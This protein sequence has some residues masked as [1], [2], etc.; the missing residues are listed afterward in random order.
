MCNAAQLRAMNGEF[1]AA[2]RFYR[3][4]RALFEALAAQGVDVACSSMILAVIELL[5]GTPDAAEAQ[6]RSDY[7]ML[8]ALGE[9][10]YLST[11][12]PLLARIFREQGRNEEALTV[13]RKAEALAAEDDV[14]AQIRW[15]SV[16]ASILA[17]TGEHEE[18]ESL[19]LIALEMARKVELPS[20]QAKVFH[21]LCHCVACGRQERGGGRCSGQAINLYRAKGDVVSAARATAFRELWFE[22]G[23][24]G[25]V[26]DLNGIPKST[27]DQ[28]PIFEFKNDNLPKS[29][30]C[31]TLLL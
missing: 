25:A 6:V 10:Y 2:R 26:P 13:T 30:K 15:R 31:V 27:R 1:D 14:D 5:A 16:R 23:I 20:L 3:E 21:Y 24:A 17:R 29:S 22:S 8:E 9:T 19:S 18:A 12:A 11:L 4:G 28:K 7:A